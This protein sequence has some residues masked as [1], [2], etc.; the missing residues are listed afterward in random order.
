M[1]C[2]DLEGVLIPEIWVGLADASG[3]DELRATTRDVGDY[4]A[5]MHMRLE[6]LKRH[7]LGMIELQQ[8]INNMAPLPGAAA[9]LER[10]RSR[11]QLAI[12]SDTFYELA[13]PLMHQLGQP[14]L[15]CHHLMLDNKGCISGYRLR[16]KQPKLHAVRA[17]QSMDYQVFAAG[18]S[19][20]DIDML[21][22]ADYGVF[23]RAPAAVHAQYS[24]FPATQEYDELWQL[25]CESDR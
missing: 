11:F 20:N 10:L 5:L 24:Q 16:Q 1:I 14:L 3:I 12:V 2:L 17:F 22:S 4:D 25:F 23:F 13:A 6:L 9:F 8:V 19:L 18:D 21:C 15:L 7:G